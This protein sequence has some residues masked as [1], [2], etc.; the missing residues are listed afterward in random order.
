MKGDF[1][2]KVI[3]K[4]LK[5]KYPWIK[6]MEPYHIGHGHLEYSMGYNLLCDIDEFEEKE[7]ID[8]RGTL[9]P[10]DMDVFKRIG[11]IYAKYLTHIVLS[12]DRTKAFDIVSNINDMIRKIHFSPA[13]PKELKLNKEP[14]ITAFIFPLTSIY[15]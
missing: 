10:D 7:G 4:S 1:E 11:E 8:V 12:K 9:N 2:L 15:I 6:G 14:M 3:K 5:Q 13:L